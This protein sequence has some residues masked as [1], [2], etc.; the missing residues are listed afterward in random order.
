MVLPGSIWLR[1]T[2]TEPK[3]TLDL[4]PKA[5]LIGRASFF[6]PFPTRRFVLVPNNLRVVFVNDF[7]VA[8]STDAV[9]PVVIVA[10]VAEPAATRS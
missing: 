3:K 7:E 8:V 2:V 10:D 5:R 1:S 4:V 9:D 6:K